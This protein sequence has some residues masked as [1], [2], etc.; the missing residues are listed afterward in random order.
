VKERWCRWLS[1]LLRRRPVLL[2]LPD[3]TRK[4][5]IRPVTMTRSRK[6]EELVAVVLPGENGTGEMV[7]KR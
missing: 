7:D 5:R 1:E 6:I 4:V 2:D 3:G